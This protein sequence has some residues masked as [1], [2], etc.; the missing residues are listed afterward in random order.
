LLSECGEERAHTL[1]AQKIYPISCPPELPLFTFFF[2]WVNFMGKLLRE[3]GIALQ[4]PIWM[5]LFPLLAFAR[6]VDVSEVMRA[7]HYY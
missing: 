1:L 2:R 5:E 4:L 3:L 7:K 6:E